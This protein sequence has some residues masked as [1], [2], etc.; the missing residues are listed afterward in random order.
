MCFFQGTT[1]LTSTNLTAGER[2]KNIS[3]SRVVLSSALASYRAMARLCTSR[4]PSITVPASKLKYL[5]PCLAL[6]S[7]LMPHQKKKFEYFRGL[8]STIR[9]SGGRRFSFGSST[10][11]HAMCELK[12]VPPQGP[13]AP[14]LIYPRLQGGWGV[15]R[16]QSITLNLDYG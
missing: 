16:I 8:G 12:K 3:F 7:C 11:H 9:P 15:Q 4:S 13:K 10:R 5:D 6:T 1:V 2:A 14:I